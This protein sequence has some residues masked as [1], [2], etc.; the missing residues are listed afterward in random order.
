MPAGFKTLCDNRIDTTRFEFTGFGHIGCRGQGEQSSCLD[1]LERI[2]SRQT[3]VKTHHRRTKIKHGLQ[4]GFIE[5]RGW[6]DRIR[7]FAEPQFTIVGCEQ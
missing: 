4:M 1:R 3:K 2:I 5:R 6:R 7:Y